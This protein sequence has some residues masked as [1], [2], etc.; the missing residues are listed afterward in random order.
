MANLDLR[1]CKPNLHISTPSIRIRPLA[2]STTLK[3]AWIKVDFPL[4]VLPTTPIFVF[5]GKVQVIPLRTIGREGLYWTW[6]FSSCILPCVGHSSFGLQSSITRGASLGI[7]VNWRILSTDI[8]LFST[9]HRFHIT[10]AWSTFRLKPYVAASPAKPEME[11][12]VHQFGIEI[13]WREFKQYHD[14]FTVRK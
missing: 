4:P 7:L 9:L 14:K 10:H 5:P 3:R 2:G 6:R 8:I 11:Q 12:L 1:S 13:L